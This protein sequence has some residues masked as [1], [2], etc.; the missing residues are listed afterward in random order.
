MPYAVRKHSFYRDSCYWLTS[1]SSPESELAEDVGAW[2]NG[3]IVAV[4]CGG[5]NLAQSLWFPNLLRLASF[6]LPYHFTEMCDK[7]GFPL[8]CYIPQWF[9]AF[10]QASL[11]GQSKSDIQNLKE[12]SVVKK[13]HGNFVSCRACERRV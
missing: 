4:H 9:Q 8:A 11:L 5:T 3:T 13:R 10:Q 6:V 12:S 7:S 1:A 2:Y